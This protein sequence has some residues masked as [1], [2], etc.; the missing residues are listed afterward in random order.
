LETLKKLAASRG[1]SAS[2]PY[3][4]RQESLHGISGRIKSAAALYQTV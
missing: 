2:F 4:L 1:V 3:S